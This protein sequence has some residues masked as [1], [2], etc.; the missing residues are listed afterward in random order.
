MD[1]KEKIC[2]RSRRNEPIENHH[3]EVYQQESATE[4]LIGGKCA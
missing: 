2:C 4:Y 1:R 3:N